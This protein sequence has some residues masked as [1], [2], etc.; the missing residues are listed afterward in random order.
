MKLSI[1]KKY[2]FKI[3][4]PLQ[5]KKLQTVLLFQGYKWPGE[6]GIRLTDTEY[7]IANEDNFISFARTD[8]R[9]HEFDHIP[10]D[11]D[12]F[13][14]QADAKLIKVLPQRSIYA[15]AGT[16]LIADKLFT[17][18]ELKTIIQNMEKIT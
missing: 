15:N 4:N 1:S 11:T 17:L 18:G 9:F 7:L 12:M 6:E 8:E 3:K 10:I 14:K 16:C 13:L 5:S 2:V